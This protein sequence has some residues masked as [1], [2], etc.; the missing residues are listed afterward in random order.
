M[1][2]LFASNSLMLGVCLESAAKQLLSVSTLQQ[3]SHTHLE[4]VAFD[5]LK[6]SS[7][8]Y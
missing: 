5:Y 3:Y 2:L 8:G 7:H 6:Y 1:V 4:K